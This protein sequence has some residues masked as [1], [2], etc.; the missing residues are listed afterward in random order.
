MAMSNTL[1][2]VTLTQL[3]AAGLCVRLALLAFGEWQDAHSTLPLRGLW[4]P[5]IVRRR[6]GLRWGD[7]VAR[8]P[9]GLAACA[10]AVK[11]TDVDYSVFSDAA[12]LVAE[13]KS[14][15]ER[16]TYRYSPLLCVCISS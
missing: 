6:N 9:D 5:R 4:F 8:G 15:Y 12:A 3:L 11:Y 1:S 16:A 2:N 10:V 14:P 7:S 13:G